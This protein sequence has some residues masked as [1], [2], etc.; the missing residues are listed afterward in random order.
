MKAYGV[1]NHNL[2]LQLK[3]SVEPE[4]F[5]TFQHK[6]ERVLHFAR[7]S[8]VRHIHNQFGF[9][10][11]IFFIL[12]NSSKLHLMVDPRD[13]TKPK[14]C[15]TSMHSTRMRT[16]RLLTV[17]RSIPGVSVQGGCLPRGVCI[18]ECNG[19]DRSPGLHS[20]E[21]HSCI[22]LILKIRCI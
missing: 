10:L 19:S 21:M 14:I 16:A 20:T 7:V 9:Y 8:E 18:P 1:L 5:P 22:A 11:I 3:S 12:F 2:K 17:S 13:M 15:V 6:V 4:I